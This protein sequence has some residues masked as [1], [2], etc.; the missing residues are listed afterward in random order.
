MTA[1]PTLPTTTTAPTGTAGQTIEPPKISEGL[2]PADFLTKLGLL[3]QGIDINNIVP[4]LP[5]NQ[6]PKDPAALAHLR[7]LR[8]LYTNVPE[9]FIS[10]AETGVDRLSLTQEHL[11]SA[12]GAQL[13]RVVVED[14]QLLFKSDEPEF[15]AEELDELWGTPDNVRIPRMERMIIDRMKDCEY[16]GV[17]V[18]FKITAICQNGVVTPMRNNA[19]PEPGQKTPWLTGYKS[20]HVEL[21]REKSLHLLGDQAFQALHH[22]AV[23]CNLV[24]QVEGPNAMY[25]PGNSTRRLWLT[26]KSSTSKCN[27]KLALRQNPRTFEPAIG[28]SEFQFD[29]VGVLG[30]M[31]GGSAQSYPISQASAP[32]VVAEPC[33]LPELPPLGED[34]VV[35]TTEPSMF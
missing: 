9:E 6:Q 8:A 1:T 21:N 3:A 25:N 16:R 31:S 22:Y 12:N 30:I 7:T 34:P 28:I 15:T 11:A 23:F 20:T 32:Q 29:D 19:Q 4:D 27:F 18:K 24:T 17:R 5:A 2:I 33:K 26:P 35:E 13:F 10:Q 14:A